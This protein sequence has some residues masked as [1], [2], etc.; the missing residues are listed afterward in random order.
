IIGIEMDGKT[1]Y[2]DKKAAYETTTLLFEAPLPGNNWPG[3]LYE[4][5]A[6]KS[7]FVYAAL[8]K[9][10]GPTLVCYNMQSKAA[11][12]I[13]TLPLQLTN[14]ERAWWWLSPDNNT[15]A[16]AAEGI[17]GGL[18]LIDLNKTKACE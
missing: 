13:T 8:P 15:I 5:D 11:F 18:W 17:H 4:K 16:L 10:G 1:G 6:D 14:D 3:P 7:A 2:Y 9:D 12:D